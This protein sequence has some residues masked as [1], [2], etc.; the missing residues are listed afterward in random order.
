MDAG[1]LVPPGPVVY[2][3][4]IGD[5]A[6][7]RFDRFADMRT[8]DPCALLDPAALAAARPS[9]DVLALEVWRP[10]VA[11]TLGRLAEADAGNVRLCG[12]DA[13]WS[14]EHLIA[15]GGV[16][17]LWTFFPDPWHKKRHHK[18]RLVTPE[19]ARLAATFERLATELQLRQSAN[20][21]AQE[22]LKG[23]RDEALAASVSKTA[24]LT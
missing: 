20:D 19:F 13:V 1:G 6:R 22:Q 3:V 9:Y 16:A 14:M 18:R 21:Q 7:A 12:V 10:G 15:P 4:T 8:W 2:G 17:E 5:D 24:F 11:E 23:A